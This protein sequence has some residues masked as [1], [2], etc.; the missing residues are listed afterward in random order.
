MRLLYLLRHRS[1]Q[2]QS[3]LRVLPSVTYYC[4]PTPPLLPVTIASR[5]MS[6]DNAYEEFLKKSQ[7]DHSRG[8]ETPQE[9]TASVSVMAESDTHPAIKNLG[10]RFYTSE[11]DEPFE[12]VTFDWSGKSIPTAGE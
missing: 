10:D 6:S 2:H 7:K 12:G 3:R 11:T 5:K 9:T 8:Y 4:A 1:F